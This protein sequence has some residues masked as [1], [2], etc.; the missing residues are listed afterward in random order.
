M[1][2]TLFNKYLRGLKDTLSP[3]KIYNFS[4]ESNNIKE[5]SVYAAAIASCASALEEIK[6]SFF[7]KTA[8]KSALDHH[9]SLYDINNTSFISNA[10]KRNMLISNG[11]VRFGS[12]RIENLKNLLTGVGIIADIEETGNEILVITVHDY[13]GEYNNYYNIV[14]NCENLLPCHL[15]IVFNFLNFSWNS[16]DAKN[17]TFNT[18]DS[19]NDS[20]DIYPVRYKE[21][22]IL[23]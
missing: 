20:W 5:L 7:I 1:K 14:L 2:N 21:T 16:H 15:E 11:S 22:E 18:L 9:L 8:D 17:L 13:L 4:A 12:G 3:L 10:E 6:N 23:S 19:Y